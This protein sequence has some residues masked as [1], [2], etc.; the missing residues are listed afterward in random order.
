MNFSLSLHS[1]YPHTP[2]PGPPPAPQPASRLAIPELISDA[3]H[4]FE[5]ALSSSSG[6][7]Y[8]SAQNRFCRFC[9]AFNLGP[10]PLLSETT[11]CSLATFLANEGLKYRSIK[12][13]LITSE[14]LLSIHSHLPGSQDSAMIWAACCI[15]FFEFLR[16]GEFTVPSLLDYDPCVHLSLSDVAVDSHSN[17]SILRLHLKQSKT[18]PYRVGVGEDRN[19]LSYAPW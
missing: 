1:P 7:S 10:F 18:D 16:S 2:P 8:N 4:Y 9:V 6:R 17:P 12:C 11:L 3:Q 14:V 19:T 15:G 13:Y 5:K